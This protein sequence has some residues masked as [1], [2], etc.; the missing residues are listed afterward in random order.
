LTTS[1]T[2]RTRTPVS[3]SPSSLCDLFPRWQNDYAHTRPHHTTTALA[4]ALVRFPGVG[5][6][7]TFRGRL[8]GFSRRLWDGLGGELRRGAVRPVCRGKLNECRRTGSGAVSRGEKEQHRGKRRFA[9]LVIRVIEPCWKQS[10]IRRQQQLSPI[11]K[12]RPFLA[13]RA[14]LIIVF[15]FKTQL[16]AS[17]NWTGSIMKDGDGERTLRF[18]IDFPMLQIL[19]DL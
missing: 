6:G 5:T 11:P 9:D 18:A 17:A 3:P 16:H 14:L 15:I 13:V 7:G 19:C 1:R 8:C 4:E 2:R 10:P 12:T